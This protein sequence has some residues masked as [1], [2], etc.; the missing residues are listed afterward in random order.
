MVGNNHCIVIE[1]EEEETTN[2]PTPIDPPTNPPKKNHWS[3]PRKGSSVTFPILI[4]AGLKKRHK[5]LFKKLTMR[6]QCDKARF[7]LADLLAMCV[8][9]D[10]LN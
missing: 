1:E 8:D 10:D 4:I 5:K 2:P 6:G 7:I 9:G 3:N